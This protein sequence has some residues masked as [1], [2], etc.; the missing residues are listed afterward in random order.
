M[1][2]SHITLEVSHLSKAYD[3]VRLL[4]DVSFCV[5]SGEMLSI[6]GQNSS[7]KTTLAK[8]L[9]GLEPYDL[10]LIHICI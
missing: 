2:H 5:H 9:C 10:S 6:V 4:S 1:M 7:F 3:S 8:I